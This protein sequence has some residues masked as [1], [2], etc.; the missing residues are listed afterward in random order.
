MV[1]G[2]G[3]SDW[4]N[5]AFSLESVDRINLLDP[6][7]V[8]A[9][10]DE[11][12]NMRNGWL[13]G[14]G[15]APDHAGLDWLSDSFERHY[16]DDSPLPHTYP[17]LEGGVE[18]EWSFGSRSVILE[19]DLEKRLGDWLGFD[20]ESDEEDSYK[21]VMADNRGWKRIAAEIRRL[22]ERHE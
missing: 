13:E 19:I 15:R 2:I 14:D 21:L 6:L 8:P 7:D 22:S 18:M 10:L 12:R 20:K 1:E 11:F 17:T 5:R 4:S 16:P 9:R 3:R